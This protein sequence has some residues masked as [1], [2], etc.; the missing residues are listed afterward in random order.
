MSSSK[1][2]YSHLE[3]PQ[4][5]SEKKT[6]HNCKLEAFFQFYCSIISNQSKNYMTNLPAFNQCLANKRYR[7]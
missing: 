7:K 3:F 6:E 1:Y 4:N 2:F 5:E